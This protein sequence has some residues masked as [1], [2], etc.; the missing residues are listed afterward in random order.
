MWDKGYCLPCA[1]AFAIQID[2]EAMKVVG[3]LIKATR[4]YDHVRLY[5]QLWKM[6]QSLHQFLEQTRNGLLI[7]ALFL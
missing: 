7:Q 6:R 1:L 2:K 4:D 5:A 3:A